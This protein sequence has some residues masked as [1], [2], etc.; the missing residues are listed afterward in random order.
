MKKS[1]LFACALAAALSVPAHADDPAPGTFTIPGTQTTM[2][3]YGYVQLDGT[4]DVGSRTGLIEDNDWASI[5]PAQ[6]LDGSAQAERDNQL[7]LTGRTTRIGFVTT[8]PTTLGNVGVKLEADFN[9][10]NKLQGESYTNSVLLRLR[11]LYGT[12]GGF[13]VGQSWTTFADLGSYADTVDFNGPGSVPLIRQAQLRY[14]ANFGAATLAV[15]AENAANPV[16]GGRISRMPDVMANF[17]VPTSWGHVSAGAVTMRYDNSVDAKQG[18]GARVSG[19]LRLGNDTL[20]A[21]AMGGEGIGRYLFNALGAF[22]GYAGDELKLWKAAGYHVGFT[23]VWMP[24]VR[25]NVVWSQTFMDRNGIDATVA[26]WDLAEGIQTT[27]D[28]IVNSDDV[29]NKRIDQAFVNTFYRFAKNA[30]VG[31]EYAYGLR[32]TFDENEGQ[33]NRV[34]F[35]FHYDFF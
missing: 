24:K 7:Y 26:D 35:S 32:T 18:Y 30:E 14:T 9:G 12:V 8:T 17:T 27:G 6:P 11:H 15:A 16:A 19:S 33:E 13:L 3:L 2:R 1:T 20:V 28:A 23:H 10:A 29:S 25:S 22:G 5:V 4:Y 34:N 21:S 31:V